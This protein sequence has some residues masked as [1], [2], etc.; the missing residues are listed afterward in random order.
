MQMGLE[1]LGWKC[2]VGSAAISV[3]VRFS[4][5]SLCLDPGPRLL[6]LIAWGGVGTMSKN[7]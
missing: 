1:V 7:V 6:S 5:G 4:S 3:Q 2:W